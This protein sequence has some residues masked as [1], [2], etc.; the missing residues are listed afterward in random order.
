MF[1]DLGALAVHSIDLKIAGVFGG[2]LQNRLHPRAERRLCAYFGGQ[3]GGYLFTRTIVRDTRK[4][5]VNN[6]S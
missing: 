4:L 6:S 3:S 5:R 1:A 2:L